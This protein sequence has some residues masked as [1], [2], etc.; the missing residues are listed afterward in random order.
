MFP[1]H[2]GSLVFSSRTRI[3]ASERCHH[4]YRKR[5]DDAMGRLIFLTEA[6]VVDEHRRRRVFSRGGS[7]GDVRSEKTDR[8]SPD[9]C[10][11][12]LKEAAGT[13]WH[14]FRETPAHAV[15]SGTLWVTPRI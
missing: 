9:S 15:F 11:F 10:N 13:V 7:A 4:R 3:D 5:H 1:A 8:R 6:I 12:Y 2:V 14:L